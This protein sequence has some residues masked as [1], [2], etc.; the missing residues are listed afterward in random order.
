MRVVRARPVQPVVCAGWPELHD[1]GK[2]DFLT[3]Q[4]ERRTQLFSRSLTSGQHG[5]HKGTG[6]VR[7]FLL[8]F[9]SDY[10][11]DQAS[12]ER[13]LKPCS[14]SVQRQMRLNNHSEL[15]YGVGKSR[16]ITVLVQTGLN[17]QRRCPASIVCYGALTS[18]QPAV[19]HH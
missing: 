17:A 7:H 12:Q 13:C 16:A 18:S 11:N 8:V 4:T 9:C 5:S 1:E 19:F 2:L 15:H 3:I 14:A 10:N 6:I